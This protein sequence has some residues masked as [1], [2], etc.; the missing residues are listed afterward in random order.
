MIIEQFISEKIN[1]ISVYI[2]AVIDHSIYY[3][4]LDNF[5]IDT[6]EEWTLL[7]VI[8]ETPSSAR[9]RV[10]WH[11][12]HELSLHGA[13]DLENNLFFRSEIL[14]CVDFFSGKGSYPIDCIGWR[15]IP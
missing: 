4:E 3:T 15:P 14:T 6:M 5:V 9:E 12:M 8:D 1:Q 10:F 7:R 11:I 13:L 2:S